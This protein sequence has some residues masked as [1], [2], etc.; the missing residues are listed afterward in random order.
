MASALRMEGGEPGDLRAGM[1]GN[2]ASDRQS[3]DGPR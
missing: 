1:E 2:W 3:G